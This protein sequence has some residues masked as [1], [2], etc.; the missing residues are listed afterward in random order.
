[1]PCLQ[2]LQKVEAPDA[3]LV[4]LPHGT[5]LGYTVHHPLQGTGLE[6]Y[7]GQNPALVDHQEGTDSSIGRP[8]Y[9]GLVGEVLT[10]SHIFHTL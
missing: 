4:P 7:G 10:R 6:A 1:M 3:W 2:A 8:T 5:H 9:H